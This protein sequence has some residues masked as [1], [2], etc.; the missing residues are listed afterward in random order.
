MLNF[1]KLR[2]RKA[3]HRVLDVANNVV[4]LPRGL[5]VS[6]LLVCAAMSLPVLAQIAGSRTVYIW[7]GTGGME[8]GV[9]TGAWG[10]GD[11]ELLPAIEG[12]AQDSLEV[13]TRNFYEGVRFSFAKPLTLDSYRSSGLLRVR[14]RSEKLRNTF[15]PPPLAPGATPSPFGSPTSQPGFNPYAPNIPGM[16]GYNPYA[17][18][19]GRPPGATPLPTPPVVSTVQIVMHLERGALFG[20]FEFNENAARPDAR[21]WQSYVVPLSQ[22]RATADASGGLKTVVIS[23][24][25]EGTFELGQL[26][27]VP[28]T[29]SN[30]ISIRR[31]EDAVGTQ[32]TQMEVRPGVLKLV[33]DVETGVSDV[34]VDWNFDADS[35]GALAAPPTDIVAATPTPVGAPGFGVRGTPSPTPS[36]RS[37]YGRPGAG[38]PVAG[39]PSIEMRTER[40]DARGLVAQVDLPNEEQ[41][42]RVEVT[43]RDRASLREIGK[44]Q[45]VVKVRSAD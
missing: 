37:G 29:N 4:R 16:P 44:A 33:A 40:L 26:A 42:Y 1:M 11:F 14:L 41:D 34:V 30:A 27:L 12:R 21:G 32:Q 23:G 3:E 39:A 35:S 36:G 15:A 13:R 31:A 2:A 24:D 28:Q 19:G 9:K 5:V 25:R 18:I 22:M 43:V 17:S 7:D 8:S 20:Q 38:A 45:L 10:N 6:T